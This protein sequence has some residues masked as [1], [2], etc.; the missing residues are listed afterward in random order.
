[1][2]FPRNEHTSQ[3]VVQQNVWLTHRL[4]VSLLIL[5]ESEFKR[6]LEYQQA[7]R[8]EIE[9]HSESTIVIVIVATVLVP[10]AINEEKYKKLQ[11]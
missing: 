4:L 11:S 5:A 9:L 10:T 1:M 2:K 3:V 7:S 6:K 8:R